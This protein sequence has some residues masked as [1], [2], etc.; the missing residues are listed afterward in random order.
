MCLMALIVKN[1]V[2]TPENEENSSFQP[3]YPTLIKDIYCTGILRDIRRAGE[4]NM[5]TKRWVCRS[6]ST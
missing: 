4:S 6:A 5:D 2:E 3:E 1:A